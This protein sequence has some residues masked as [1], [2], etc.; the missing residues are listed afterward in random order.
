[1]KCD[2]DMFGLEPDKATQSSAKKAYYNL[3]LLV[4]PD[5]NTCPDKSTANDE[6]Q[7]VTDSYNRILTD[8][9]HRI[10]EKTFIECDNLADIHKKEIRKLDRFT[11]EMPSFMDIYLETHDDMKKFNKLWESQ[12]EENVDGVIFQTDPG[13][14]IVESEYKDFDVEYDPNIDIGPIT[15][16]KENREQIISIENL[17]TISSLPEND[18]REAF[19]VPSLLKDRMPISC[20]TRFED[21]N[22]VEKSFQVLLTERNL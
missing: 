20:I 13:Y 3:A 5:R 19:G 1:M 21:L 18:Y 6:M 8:I 9:E 15:E 17:G 14:E 22:D 2:Y 11:K 12:K 4:H 16:F 7:A 10:Q